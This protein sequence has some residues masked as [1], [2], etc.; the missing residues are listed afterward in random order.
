MEEDVQNPCAARLCGVEQR[1]NGE[2]AKTGV[3]VR[4]GAGLPSPWVGQALPGRCAG[5]TSGRRWA[6]VKEFVQQLSPDKLIP[7]AGHPFRV[8]EDESLE[9]LM[10]SVRYYGVL[11]PLL[12]RSK[13][14]G[15][16]LLSGHRRR[17][18]T[19]KLGL[20]TIPVLVWEISD[21][22]AICKS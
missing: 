11:S 16:E 7:F 1:R 9:E 10:E 8:R 14:D 21:D 4:T 19:A 15:Y 18:A 2:C 20:E 13:G 22:E 3:A 6:A 17:L 12:A 5:G